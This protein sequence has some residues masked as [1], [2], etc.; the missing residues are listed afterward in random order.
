MKNIFT[1]FVR[2]LKRLVRSPFALVIA[3][4]LCILPSLYAW[5]NIYSN[6]DP[7][8]NT[9]NIKIAIASADEGCTLSDGTYKNMGADVL[10]ELETNDSIDWIAC[11]TLE[12]AIAGVE[13]GD[14]YA[15][16]T[17]SSDFTESMYTV[18]DT[19][20]RHPSI[21]YYEN[22]KKN[23]IATKITD[24]AVGS[25]QQT[26]NA[27]F[28]EVV[29]STIFTQTNTV[30]DDINEGERTATLHDKLV[31]LQENLSAYND[32]LTLLVNGNT[33]LTG[34]L[35]DTSSEI[36][37]LASG[38]SSATSSLSNAQ[39]S[40]SN[41][42]AALN[43]FSEQFKSTLNDM[44]ES[45]NNISALL[46]TTTLAQDSQ[47]LANSVSQL[48]ADITQLSTQMKTLKVLVAKY[49]AGQS[50][51]VEVPELGVL[52]AVVT[53][54]LNTVSAITSQAGNG[55]LTQAAVNNLISGIKSSIDSCKKQIDDLNSS[56][57]N[58]VEPQ[59][60]SLNDSISQTLSSVNSIMSSLTSALN[61]ATEILSGV[62]ATVDKSNES[63]SQIQ[64]V[65]ANVIAELDEVIDW[66]DSTSESDKINMVTQFLGGDSETYGEFFAEP[67]N[68]TTEEIYPVENY[69]SGM[70][71]FYTILALWV[72]G[73]LLVSLV[74]VHADADGLE[75]VKP[76]HLFF[77][78]YLTFFVLGQIQAAI[79]AIGDIHLL[80]SQVLEPG[81]FYLVAVL[82]SFTFTLLIYSLAI[83]FGDLGKALAVVVMVLQIAGS[84]GTFPIEMLP[85]VYRNI[86]I[87]FPFPYAINAMRETVAGMYGTAYIANLAQLMLF[88]V[89]AL[90]IGLV[91]R[92][93]F[94]KINHFVEERMEDTG[95][96]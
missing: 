3:L 33:Q 8:G 19:D 53:Q 67:V 29:V 21:T 93:P 10:K 54:L 5:F 89:A 95:M 77:G 62:E 48:N 90:V 13:A 80:H 61:D 9:S 73:T 64:T 86:Y 82:A 44:S 56:Y 2:D 25:L 12:E 78:R 42:R 23:A 72:G 63:L 15:C 46:D 92:I 26:I 4:G 76:R 18:F 31:S 35:S 84:S 68:M 6:H 57:V 1:I 37:S 69:G 24:T 7:Y 96:M 28:I 60:I 16:V 88:A 52:D 58:S 87:F 43:T 66:M 83:S 50:E 39:A 34:N 47:A 59:L 38:I 74:K 36:S 79:V 71:P 11:D 70:T 94:M 65:I 14:Y 75:N 17:I 51:S 27:K 30:S 40:F 55:T 32:T 22:E 85:Q 41:S 20:F 49:Y 81:L 91:I 45:L